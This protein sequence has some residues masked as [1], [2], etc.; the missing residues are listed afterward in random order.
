MMDVK[1]KYWS[2]CGVRGGGCCALGLYGG[3]PSV[4]TCGVCRE[5]DDG[6]GNRTRPPL[7]EPAPAPPFQ[8]VPRD[9]WPI[10]ADS[11][12]KLAVESDTGIGDVVERLARRT[13]AKSV[14]E[15]A[16]KMG[17]PDCGC[18]DRRVR[19]N[20]EYPLRKI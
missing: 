11:L 16:K 9:Q 20:A 3:R 14:V 1:C 12:A 2:E 6:L 10:W 13:L 4:G 18:A 5:H 17:L 7:P 8:P 15:F 19:W